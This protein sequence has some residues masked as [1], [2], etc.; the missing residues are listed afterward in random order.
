MSS[1][2]LFLPFLGI[3]PLHLPR[4]CRKLTVPSHRCCPFLEPFQCNF[5]P[6]PVTWFFAAS[7][8]SS[9]QRHP[10]SSNPYTHHFQVVAQSTNTVFTAELHTFYMLKSFPRAHTDWFSAASQNTSSQPSTAHTIHGLLCHYHYLCP[11]RRRF[12]ENAL[13]C[14]FK[15]FPGIQ[16]ILTSKASTIDT[17]ICQI[18]FIMWVTIQGPL[19]V[20]GL[21]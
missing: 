5:P 15:D 4:N 1:E 13:F 8:N 2:P 11:P 19:V 21:T 10:H 9:D 6:E 14:G 7:Q 18:M 20:D 3:A 17:K 16:E 12:T